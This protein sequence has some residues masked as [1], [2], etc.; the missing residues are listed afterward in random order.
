MSLHISRSMLLPTVALAV[1]C[2]A[3][4]AFAQAGSTF[5]QAVVVANRAPLDL[6]Q[7]G[8]S[9]TVIDQS[10][11][12][13]LQAVHMSDLLAQTPGITVSGNGG[14]G[15]PHSL[16]I[17]GAE[18]GQTLVL[19]DG[20]QMSD[21]SSTDNSYDFGNLLVGDT[22][23]IE[24]LRGSASTLYGSQAIG[25]VINIVS[26]TPDREGLSGDLQGEGGSLSTGLVRGGISGKFDKLTFR[27]A[28]GFYTTDSVSTFDS[29]FGGRETDPYRNQALSGR[30]AYAFT[31][32]ISLDVR[33]FYTNGKTNYDGFPP[34]Q[35]VFADE[36]DYGTNQQFVGYAG[37]NVALLDGRLKNR[38][39]YQATAT[40]RA[41]YIDTGTSV[42]R[43]GR[44]SGDNRRLE[45]Q[46]NFAIADGYSAVF[47]FQ[48]ENSS[49]ASPEPAHA[50]TWLNSY[51]L[52]LTGEVIDGLT[53]TA[54][55][56]EDDHKTF[57]GHFTGELSAAY[58]LK[59]T[60][61]IFRASWGQGFKAPSLYQLYSI[62]GTPGLL[63]EQ[64]NSWDAGVEQHLLD[65]R[66]ILSATY[67]S[68]HSRNLINF[69][70]PICPGQPQCATQPVGFYYNT[71]KTM[72]NGVELQASYEIL[73]GLELSSNYTHELARDKTVGAI[74]YGMLLPRRP[75]DT[76]NT[77]LDYTFGFGLSAGISTLYRSASFDD[78]GNTRRLG[79]Y[80]LVNI[81]ASYPI[82]DQLEAYG[83][84]DNLGDAFYETAYQ[85]GTW[86]RTMFV[87]L[88]AHF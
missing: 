54:G 31:P 56:R 18:A 77:A 71:G 8:N 80:A 24:I 82:S 73:D 7:I 16:R 30:A 64:S 45:Y 84:I 10:A 79:G 34:P 67:F 2:A 70:T 13:R 38:L 46:G 29:H 27:L 28:G 75:N 88:R 19:I 11:I 85:Y 35:F 55:G 21:P 20:V 65:D 58:D 47:G 23:R 72:T 25:G 49:I 43:T 86:G 61:T 37:L 68:R 76:W 66:L 48:N 41:D 44:Y 14:P 81:R 33:A 87:G 22:A 26:A 63:P 69:T 39:D 52:Q 83:R 57:G 51:Y 42:T 50:H 40:D 60:G 59:E 5:E 3:S 17:R 1:L 53:L 12:T 6:A 32:D 15:T 9:V 62:Y 78:A 36:G 74:T 4:G